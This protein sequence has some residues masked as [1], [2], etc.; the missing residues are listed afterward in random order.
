MKD[1][2]TQAI[3]KIETKPTAVPLGGAQPQIDWDIGTAY[4]LFMSL[5]VLHWPEKFG[6]RASWAAGVRSRLS[7][8]ERKTLKAANHLF[9]V[10]L[11][12]I[13]SLP[14]PK[15]ADTA[16]W[17]LRRIP[18]EDRIPTLSFCSQTHLELR[19]ILENVAGRGSWDEQD[20]E[21]LREGYKN[22]EHGKDTPR[23]KELVET[24]DSWANAAEFGEKYLSALQSYYSAFFA[25]EQR[26]IMPAIQSSLERAKERA[27]ELA[28][29]DLI[30]ELS[31]GIRFEKAEGRKRVILIPSYW[32]TPLIYS[33]ELDEESML[34]AFGGRPEDESIVPGEQ[35]PEFLLLGLKAL[36]DP[37]RLRILSYL[38]HEDLSPADLARRLRLRPPTVT[39]H[40]RALRLAGLVHL[41]VSSGKETRYTA[42]L[43]TADELCARLNMFLESEVD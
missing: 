28:L 18:A 37:T 11:C 23:R 39:H 3:D 6:L 1:S 29:P 38:N 4:D 7:S 33:A 43:E 2:D 13:H 27:G 9:H 22:W 20:L 17:A 36:S 25:E 24:L 31:R 32:I 34:I 5:Y 8:Q 10:P 40:L 30:E 16:L 42:R 41:T 26:R 14:E 35:V 12:W 21:S 19:E 15:D